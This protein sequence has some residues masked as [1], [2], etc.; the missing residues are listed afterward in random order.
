[1][2]AQWAT[3]YLSRRLLNDFGKWHNDRDFKA[4]MSMTSR[5]TAFTV[6]D[7]KRARYVASYPFEKAGVIHNS[8]ALY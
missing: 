6:R 1:M 7:A 8:P 5:I 4:S 2:A 3:Q